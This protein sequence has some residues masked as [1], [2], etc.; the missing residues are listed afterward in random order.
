[1]YFFFID[2][3]DIH[4]DDNRVGQ[5]T[6]QDKSSFSFPYNATQDKSLKILF[7]PPSFYA[8][9]GQIWDKLAGQGSPKQ[10]R[11]A[12]CLSGVG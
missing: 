8:Q 2:R 7:F 1:M 5:E 3:I 9:V 11:S 10:G 4:W 6:F 12:A